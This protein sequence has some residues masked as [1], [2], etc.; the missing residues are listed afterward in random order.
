MTRLAFVILLTT[1]AVACDDS[2]DG[3]CPEPKAALIQGKDA[4]PADDG[5]KPKTEG[6]GAPQS[7]T[8]QAVATGPAPASAPTVSP[9]AGAESAD[10]M[11]T[12]LNAFRVAAGLPAATL[13]PSLS[14]GAQKH[15]AYISRNP[16]VIATGVGAHDED[17]ALPGF[18]EEGRAA[19]R[20]AT[21]N[22]VPP[23]EA[24][25]GW[26]ATLYHRIPLIRAAQLRVGVGYAT[27]ENGQRHVTVLDVVRGIGDPIG[28]G[29]VVYPADG[30]KNV[31]LEFGPEVP[32]PVPQRPAGYPIT[33]S[34]ERGTVTKVVAKLT[35][36]GVDVPT[37]L[38]TPEK[39]ATYFDQQGTV[40]M[41]PTAP[42]EPNTSYAAHVSYELD[43]VAKSRTWGFTTGSGP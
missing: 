32:D 36:G 43:G 40:C 20:A 4:K 7:E 39:P 42:L 18:S 12:D 13:D 27:F 16:D 35:K 10:S 11:L 38:S 1:L 30:A 22:Y 19:G 23:S 34:N 31:P 15:A 26:M 41:I 33:L 21:I 14:T 5:C 3:A 29:E 28:T 9:A 8:E 17:P 24:V 37:H 2:G 6:V 25:R